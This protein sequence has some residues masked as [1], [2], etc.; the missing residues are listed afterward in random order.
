MGH[1]GDEHHDDEGPDDDVESPRGAPPDPLDRVW[2]HPAEL[3]PVATGPPRRS[4]PSAA[5]ALVLPL[6][7]GAL[8]ALVTVGVLAAAGAFDDDDPGPV[9]APPTGE[10]AE[11][12]RAAA[13]PGLGVVSVVVRDG[14][15]ARRVSGVS[16]RHAGELLTSVA[17]L[18][19]ADAA[20]VTTTDGQQIEA[21]VVG[22][23]VTTDLALL[24]V[25]EPLP[26]APVASEL[27]DVGARVWIVGG[28]GAGSG[29]WKSE[30]IVAS[31]D[32]LLAHDPGPIFA[33]LI[34]VTAPGSELS[35]GGA[36]VNGDGEV[37]GVVLAPVPGQRT[38]YA[39]PI[40][41]AVAI[42]KELRVDGT[43]S[44]GAFEVVGLDTP[45]GPVVSVV[46]PGGAADRA[47]VEPGDVVMA[48]GERGV[49]D[50]RELTASIRR[51]PPGTVVAVQ[52]VR[53]GEPLA[54][55]VELA[56]TSPEATS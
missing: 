23:D 55:E 24:A 14:M 17:A 6:T 4:L 47:G 50:M 38:A 46:E 8:G 28:S 41:V 9:V 29:P 35:A 40:A 22:R 44:H 13:D 39:V 3:P 43:A 26:A 21:T 16:L 56:G 37:V 20:L 19:G 10:A 27:P 1:A 18:G 32:A 49:L 5:R 48:V 54:V 15:D 2:V 11:S 7:F 30:G 33:G 53:G 45:Q 42:A 25:N 52:L 51:H 12:E 31:T 36:L 34:E